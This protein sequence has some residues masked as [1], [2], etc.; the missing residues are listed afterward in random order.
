M[1]KVLSLILSVVLA[2]GMIAPAFAEGMQ[3]S[4]WALNDLNE[5]E[6]YGLYTADWYEEGFQS[7][8]TVEQL[9][10]LRENMMKR[11][12]AA[13]FTRKPTFA[14]KAIEGPM[15]RGAVALVYYDILSMY[16]LAEEVDPVTALKKLEV[17]KGGDKGLDLEANCTTQQAVI[18]ATRV[19]KAVY[20]Q[21]EA[22]AKGIMWKVSNK[23]ITLYLV[24]TIHTGN[25]HLFP[26]SNRLMNAFD[27]S[28]ALILEALMNQDEI[29]KFQK[30][31][32]YPEGKSIRDDLSKE[33][34]EKLEKVLALEGIKLKDV[35]NVRA[36]YLMNQYMQA[37]ITSMSSGKPVATET[38]IKS[39][40]HG[41]SR[42][43]LGIDHYFISKAQLSGKPMAQ[44]ESLEQQ[45]L[46]FNQLSASLVEKQL[47]GYLDF[48]LMTDAERNQIKEETAKS[49]T[50]VDQISNWLKLWKNGDVDGFTKS[51]APSIGDDEFSKMLFGKRDEQMALR[52]KE[53][54]ESG[55]K[56]TYFV[57]VGSGHYVG[58]KSIIYN[59][60]NMGFTVEVCK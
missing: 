7:T 44:L 12:D 40:D 23:D 18:M 39:I 25:N 37:M 24:G 3:V 6:R 4:L 30:Q 11:F 42:V 51:F 36:W 13:G 46:L 54:L 10:F 2:L 45:A 49:D 1:K 29:A 55:E 59:L 34:L 57:A 15:T 17:L 26:M 58:D 48:F 56:G 35:E 5:G 52:L 50:G 27:S 38:A 19:L 9:T 21:N 53:L 16:Q 32:Y 20:A 8:V 33:T 28:D 22:G 43:E 60:K 47:S 14:L 41:Q 31:L